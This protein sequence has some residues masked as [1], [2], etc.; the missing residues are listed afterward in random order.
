MKAE[1]FLAIL[2]GVLVCITAWYAY[3]TMKLGKSAKES[4]SASRDA[5]EASARSALVAQAGLGVDFSL[6]PVYDAG[7]GEDVTAF[8]GVFV[9]CLAANVYVHG[10][11]LDSYGWLEKSKAYGRLESMQEAGEDLV[12]SELSPYALNASPNESPYLL[13]RTEALRFALSDTTEIPAVPKVSSLGVSVFYSL[14]G[15]GEPRR[16]FVEWFDSKSLN[17]R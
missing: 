13:H 1:T 9:K 17:R 11:R 4:A 14:D 8:N 12:L 3:L 6:N 7:E 16:R 5:A 10:A 15:L 2:N